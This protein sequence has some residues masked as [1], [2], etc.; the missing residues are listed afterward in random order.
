[1]IMVREFRHVKMAK[2]AGRAFDPEGI[3]GTK[4]GVLAIPCRACPQ[5]KWNLPPGWEAARPEKAYA[6][7]I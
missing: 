3:A 2:R 6:L 1:M 4:P 5:P 7:S